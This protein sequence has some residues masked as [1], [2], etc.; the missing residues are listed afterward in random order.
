MLDWLKENGYNVKAEPPDTEALFKMLLYK[1]V[2]AILAN[3]FVAE[4]IIKKEN[5]AGRL[6]SAIQQDQPLGVYFSKAF[7]AKNPGF[8]DEFNAGV[9][10]YFSK[11]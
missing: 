9:A 1:R 8:L 3:N 10:D 5:L 4:E 6:K 11:K 2:D 7:L